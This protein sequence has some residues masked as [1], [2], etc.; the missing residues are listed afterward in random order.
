MLSVMARWLLSGAVSSLAFDAHQDFP[1]SAPPLSS[2]PGSEGLV[3]VQDLTK[4]LLGRIPLSLPRILQYNYLSPET[5]FIL[6]LKASV[7]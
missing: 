5:L 7:F 4:P 2:V 6:S 1:G 3:Q